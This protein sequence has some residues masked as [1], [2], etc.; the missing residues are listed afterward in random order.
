MTDSAGNENDITET[1]L[2][3]YMDVVVGIVLNEYNGREGK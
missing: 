2:E 3:R 1:N